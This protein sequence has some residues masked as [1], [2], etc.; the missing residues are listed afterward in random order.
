MMKRRVTYAL[1]TVFLTLNIQAQEVITG[2]VRNRQVAEARTAGL[3]PAGPVM[4]AAAAE[5]PVPLPFSDD[6][7]SDTI[8]PSTARWSDMQAFI[9]NTF[10][11]RQPSA[12][13]ATLDCLDESGNLHH[14]ASQAVFEAD[15]L[16]SRAI[17]LAYQ[18]SVSFFLCFFFVAGGIADKP[19]ADDCLTLRFWAPGD[20]KW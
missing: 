16:T 17:D 14:G 6:F 20:E 12:G 15:H 19:V 5:E 9:N 10:S 3:Q 1:L 13:I 7:S 4:K 11:V 18:P 8:F 2:L